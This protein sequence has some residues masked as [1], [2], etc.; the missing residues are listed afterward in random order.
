[1][2]SLPVK[3]MILLVVKEHVASRAPKDEVLFLGIDALA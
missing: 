3:F 1:M 2:Y